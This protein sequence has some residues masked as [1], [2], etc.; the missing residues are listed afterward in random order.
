MKYGLLS[1]SVVLLPLFPVLR[2]H[3]KASSRSFAL[4]MMYFKAACVTFQRMISNIGTKEWS[5]EDRGLASL[6]TNTSPRQ[7]VL[8]QPSS[9]LQKIQLKSREAIYDSSKINFVFRSTSPV[10]QYDGSQNKDDVI[11]NALH[12]YALLRPSPDHLD[13]SG[14]DTF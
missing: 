14:E 8:P 9:F 2:K 4:L 11:Q 12:P 10:P 3:G 13:E 5:R 7:K 1:L 6:G